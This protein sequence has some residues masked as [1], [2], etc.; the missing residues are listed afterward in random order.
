MTGQPLE[1][2]VCGT[3][4]PADAALL[5]GTVVRWCGIVV[6]A[7]FSPRSLS[8]EQAAAVRT[9]TDRDVVVL[10]CEPSPG[11]VARVVE[12]VRPFAI[13]LQCAETPAEVA[14]V[15]AAVDCEV[16]KAVHLPAVASQASPAAYVRAGA[17]R[18]VL[19]SQVAGE[20]GVRFGGT[21]RVGDW[22]RMADW[23]AGIR[24]VPVMLAGG[25]HAGNLHEAVRQ[26]GP[27]GVDLCSGVERQVGR[28]DPK[29][30]AEL[31]AAWH[32]LE[33]NGEAV[34]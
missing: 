9:A 6:E 28:R 20:A 13:Q 10:L 12:H 21:G 4:S 11:L 1:L 17:D 24:E 3:T 23:M 29:R 8:V 5:N 15:R 7:D 18:L 32:A 33:P 27:A 19:D 25:I 14:R 16:W 26:T 22:G 2:K 30:L 31:L 34:G